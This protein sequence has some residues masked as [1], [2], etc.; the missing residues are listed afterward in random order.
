MRYNQLDRT[1]LYVSEPCLGTMIFGGGGAAVVRM[2]A[3]W[4]KRRPILPR[5]E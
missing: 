4:A 1:G 5:R 3:E 2:S